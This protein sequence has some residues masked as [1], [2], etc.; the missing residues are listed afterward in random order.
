MPHVSLSRVASALAVTAV[1]IWLGLA[2]TDPTIGWVIPM[3][4]V[5]GGLIS[6][7]LLVVRSRQHQAAFLPDSFARGGLD[8]VIDISHVRVA[9][10]GGLGLVIVAAAVT[11][12]IS[13][14]PPR[15]PPAWWEV[16]L[17]V[18]R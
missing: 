3:A 10:L 15:L 7:V 6:A 1:V 11:F 9:D 13:S 18:L 12:S 14:P 5:G 4:L 2:A 8:N 17:A 16:S